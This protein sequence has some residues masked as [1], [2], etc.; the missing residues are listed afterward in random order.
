MKNRHYGSIESENEPP[1]MIKQSFIAQSQ[2]EL[3]DQSDELLLHDLKMNIVEN[4]SHS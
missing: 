2:N 1:A 3:L 4:N